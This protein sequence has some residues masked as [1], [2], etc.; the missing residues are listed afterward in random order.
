M[1]TIFYIAVLTI[2]T[3]IWGYIFY[4]KD[5]HPQPIK[6][7]IQIFGI[8]LFSMMPV[9]GYKYIYQNYLPK[10][11]EYSIFQPLFDSFILKGI[12]FF[13]LNLALLSFILLILS[14]LLTGLLTFFKHETIQ[15]IKNS[16]KD[17]EFGFV[18]VS[19]MVGIL[20]YLESF[21]EDIWNMPIVNT[22]LGTILFLTIIEEFIKH[23]VVRFVDDKKI[24]DID[25]A[26]TLSIMVGLAFSLMETIV[27][28]YT[29]GDMS[30]IIYRSLLT[31]PV[32]LIASA[33]FGY[34]YGLSHFA[35]PIIKKDG[36]EKTY[37]FNINWIHRILTLK[38]ST[39]YEEE[40]IVEGMGLAVL[41]HTVCNI[42][43]ELNLAYFVIPILVIGLFFVSNSYK[44]SL[45][46]Y[47][48]LHIH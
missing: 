27:Y 48:K 37:K 21:L 33:I 19:V 9:F 13:I 30:L 23:L 36:G 25:D 29:S 5:Y 31:I 2:A 17:I 39:V 8:G 7:I 35:K 47:K 14:G 46:I 26:I 1:Q 32:H 22:I 10:L 15:N 18:T 11:A 45:L 6:V 16:I 38:K 3:F 24:K 20:I 12:L 41:F 34:Y 42:L 4:K 40:K 44:E 43:S 28:A